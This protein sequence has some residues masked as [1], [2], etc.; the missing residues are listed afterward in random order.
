MYSSPGQFHVIAQPNNY[1]EQVKCS[2]LTQEAKDV[3]ASEIHQ[4]IYVTKEIVV[5]RLRLY[6]STHTYS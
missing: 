5:K 2:N 1:D 6:W 4:R 3:Q